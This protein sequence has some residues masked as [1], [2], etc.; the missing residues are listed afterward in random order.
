[1]NNNN[2]LFI[3]GSL[4]QDFNNPAF[5][6][7][8]QYFNFVGNAYVQGKLVDMGE[9]PAGVFSIEGHKIIGELYQIKQPEQY[10]WAFAQLDD[11][12]G[13]L[14]EANETPDFI[15]QQTTVFLPNNETVQSW[16]Y[17]Y[18]GNTNNNPIIESG[19]I[20]DFKKT[21]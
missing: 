17:W 9:F 4:R 10:D 11:F 6:Y 5:S 13:V 7:I 3:Y 16:I 18:N 2:F 19:N 21:N 15:R 8:S 14:V 20:F 12:E 1:M